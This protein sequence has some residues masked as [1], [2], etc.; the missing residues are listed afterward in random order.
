MFSIIFYAIGILIFILI[1]RYIIITVRCSK[2]PAVIGEVVSSEMKPKYKKLAEFAEA[3]HTVVGIYRPEITYTY[4]VNGEKYTN[5]QVRPVGRNVYKDKPLVQRV[6]NLFPEGYK[7]YIFYN[8]KNPHNSVLD[9][10]IRFSPVAITIPTALIFLG[11]GFCFSG[12]ISLIPLGIN[13]I[14]FAL[15]IASVLIIG[16]N[17]RYL[18]KVLRSKKWPY[19]EGEIK[20]VMIYRKD[21]DQTVSY[22]VDVTYTYEIEGQNYTNHQIKLDFVHGARTFMPKIFAMMKFEQF[23]EGK[24]INVFYDPRNPNESI[25]KHGLRYFTFFLMLIVGIGLFLFSF[26]VVQLMIYDLLF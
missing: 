1:I 21:E 4:Q 20:K 3:A 13:F 22:N 16:Q 5:N 9:P 23:E 19:V 15:Y 12:I 14:S 6:L 25:L 26:F 10:W 18:V 2:W 17:F 8:P 7:V 11:L 24:K